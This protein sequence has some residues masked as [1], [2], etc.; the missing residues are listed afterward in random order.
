MS[1]VAE[2][3]LRAAFKSQYHSG[4]AML[5]DAVERCPDE[6]WDDDA[7]T[8]RFWQVAYHALYFLHLYLQP[9]LEDFEPWS[10]HQVDVQHDDGIAGPADPES[11]LPLIPDP[12]AR[13]EVLAY[14]DFCEDRIDAWVDAID[15]GS[16]ESG[17]HWYPVAKIEHQLV[18]V[19]HL[20]HHTAQLADRLR[21]EHDVGVRWIGSRHPSSGG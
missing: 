20:Q 10:G 5:R 14:C 9:R 18:N 1:T 16:R 7:Y 13:V 21:N 15:F 6:L 2:D 4:L 11:E 17:F 8:N 12:Y 19:K 3:A